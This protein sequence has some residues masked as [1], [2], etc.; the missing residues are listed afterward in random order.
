MKKS[1]IFIWPLK[2]D[3]NFQKLWVT[4]KIVFILLLCGLALPAFSSKHDDPSKTPGFDVQQQIK[5]TGKVTDES[6]NQPMPGVNIQVKGTIV[7]T[8]SDPNGNFTINVIDPN[9]ILV[10]SFIGYTTKE[11]PLEGKISVNIV[12]SPEVSQIGEVVVIGYGTAKKASLTG[13][14]SA[15]NGNDLKQSPTT[16]LTNSLIGRL[17]G[18][19]AIQKS[20]EPGQD[21]TTITIRGANTLGDNAPLIVVDGIPQRSLERLDP[22]DIE[23]MT[24]LKDASAAIYGTRA[25]N[26][27][28][29]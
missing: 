26:G 15:V 9:S 7:G 12:L 29:L 27:V 22:S 8:I 24:I 14:I 18:I 20:G 5:I 13:S 2:P 25:A 4:M 16:N 10:L 17:P 3:V 11:I 1:Q 28:I 23:S 19:T 21:A 6:T